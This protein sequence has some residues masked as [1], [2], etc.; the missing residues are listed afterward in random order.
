MDK[1]SAAR[2]QR[3]REQIAKGEKKRLQVVI[4]RDE[5][6]KLDKICTAEGISKTDFIRRAIESWSG[7]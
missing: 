2:Q 6:K 4:D 7:A 1:T 5:A 3:Y